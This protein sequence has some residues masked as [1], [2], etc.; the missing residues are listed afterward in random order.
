MFPHHIL[1]RPLWSFRVAVTVGFRYCFMVESIA[2]YKA[3]KELIHVRTRV[4]KAL[5]SISATQGWFTANIQIDRIQYLREL[6]GHRC[7]RSAKT[8]HIIRAC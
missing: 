2:Q 3:S 1:N 8:G 4:T 5:L 6:G 7:G